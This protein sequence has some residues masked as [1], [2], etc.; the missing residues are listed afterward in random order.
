MRSTVQNGLESL[1]GLALVMAGLGGLVAGGVYIWRAPQAPVS[2]RTQPTKLEAAPQ[3]LQPQQPELPTPIVLP[4]PVAVETFS[5]IEEIPAQINQP[6]PAPTLAAQ[7]TPATRS[8]AADVVSNAAA[9]DVIAADATDVAADATAVAKVQCQTPNTW[10]L[11]TGA[12]GKP[13]ITAR[14]GKQAETSPYF[15]QLLQNGL[16][17]ANAPNV[18]HPGIDFGVDANTPLFAVADGE[19]ISTKYSDL[20]GKHVLM[21]TRE[22]EVLYAHLNDIFV[23]AGQKVTCSQPIGLSGATGKALTG[24]HLHLELRNNGKPVDPM[25]LIKLALAADKP[26]WLK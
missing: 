25:P 8:D 1:L 17:P 13:R 9:A 15:L 23:Q 6:E 20:Y 12:V 18:Y 10:F 22:G 14:F 3:L 26:D 5:T 19:V 11:P 24:A 21:K 16:I 2:V 7:P 4:T